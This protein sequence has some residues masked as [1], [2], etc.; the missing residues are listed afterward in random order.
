[1]NKPK[2]EPQSGSIGAAETR[3][4]F[5]FTSLTAFLAH[6]NIALIFVLLVIG[7]SFVSSDFF[8][9]RNITNVLRQSAV[10]GISSM[11]M[12]FVILTG[13]IDLS[14]GSVSAC[15]SVLV[16]LFLS[17]MPL[18]GAIAGAVLNGCAMGAISGYLIAGRRMPA[19]V[20]T[21]GMLTIARGTAFI[22][23]KGQPILVGANGQF[24]NNFGKGLTFGIAN[25]VILM[26]A[27]FAITWFLLHYTAFGRLVTQEAVRLSGISIGWYIFA[28]YVI[29]GGLSA[30]AGVVN[31][32]RSG[33][34]SPVLGI[35]ME[36]DVIAA[37]VI[38]GASLMGGRGTAFNALLGVLIL[39]VIG[40]IMNLKN[41]PGYHQEVVKG[42]IILVA[43]L[44]QSGIWTRRA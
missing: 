35:G 32:A 44:F 10:V 8:T 7:A 39:A 11:G 26:L 23:S 25:P 37:V 29:S 5:D 21:L 20:V 28:T 3:P 6:Y 9:Q 40:N 34:G 17:T 43:V 27:I 4:R 41:V 31:T 24:L 38:G 16:A 19:F 18:P 15:G 36:L 14:V 22:V 42:V 2:T 33:V 13:G 1:L 30:L 12:L